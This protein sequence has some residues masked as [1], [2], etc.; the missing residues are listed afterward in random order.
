MTI[1]KNQARR[2]SSHKIR[3][4][5]E[6]MIKDT[7]KQSDEGVGYTKTAGAESTRKAKAPRKPPRGKED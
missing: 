3:A 6:K 4:W 2:W 1:R 7:M 5:E